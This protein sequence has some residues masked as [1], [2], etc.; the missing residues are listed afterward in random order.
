M[1]SSDNSAA[2]DCKIYSCLN[3]DAPRSFFLFAGAGSGK[4]ES[5]VSVLRKFRNECSQRLRLNGQKAA[6]ITYTNAACDE[7]KRRI[8]FDAVFVVSTIHTFS[9]ALIK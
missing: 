2:V 8:E 6:V 7:I 3:L 4:T 5:L 1:N 9:L